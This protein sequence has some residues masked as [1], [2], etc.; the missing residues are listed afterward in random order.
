LIVWIDAQLSPDLAPWVT[1][2]F[3]VEAF[4]IRDLG[5][6]DAKDREIY[7]AAREAGTIVMT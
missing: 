2:T 5:L 4:A 6:R 1:G 7:Q 3:G